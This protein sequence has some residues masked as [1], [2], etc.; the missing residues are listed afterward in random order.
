M[1]LLLIVREHVRTGVNKSAKSADIECVHCSM[2]PRGGTA[3]TKIVYA[4][5]PGETPKTVEVTPSPLLHLDY[6][7]SLLLQKQ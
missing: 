5:V 7:H 1:Y 6:R 3:F 4:K 2:T